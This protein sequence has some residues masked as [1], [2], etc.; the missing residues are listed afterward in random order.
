MKVMPKSEI[1]LL[2]TLNKGK[3]YQYMKS[4]EVHTLHVVMCLHFNEHMPS[5]N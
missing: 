4:A 5:D 1:I 3:Y 2:S